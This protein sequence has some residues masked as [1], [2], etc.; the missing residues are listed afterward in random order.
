MAHINLIRVAC[1]LESLNHRYFATADVCGIIKVWHSTLKTTAIID[2]DLKQAM[3]YNS[4][5]ELTGVLDQQGGS[6][7]RDTAMI[8]CALKNNKILLVLL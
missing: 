4:M 1:S 3:S 6:Q 5:I 7:F 8:A 2:I